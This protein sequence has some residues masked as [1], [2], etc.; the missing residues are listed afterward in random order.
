VRL[1]AFLADSPLS[2]GGVLPDPAG[3]LK[4]VEDVVRAAR[5]G[6]PP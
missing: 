3:F 4:P 6:G 1:A 2:S 5:P